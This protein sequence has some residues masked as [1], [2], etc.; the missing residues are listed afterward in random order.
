MEVVFAIVIF[1][2]ICGFLAR[3]VTKGDKGLAFIL[4]LLLGPIG[5]LIAVF[6]KERS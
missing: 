6:I 5:I 2:V 1:A 4:G 3:A